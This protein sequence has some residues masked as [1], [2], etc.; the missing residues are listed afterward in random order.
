[1]APGNEVGKKEIM[2]NLDF[3]W[4]MVSRKDPEK[5]SEQESDILESQGV[6]RAP[7]GLR[8]MPVDTQSQPPGSRLITSSACPSGEQERPNT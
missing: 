5:V 4:G 3:S 7:S 1:M 2:E 8:S 6:I